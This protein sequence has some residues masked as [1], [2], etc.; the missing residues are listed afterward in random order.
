MG[1]KLA[2][3]LGLAKGEAHKWHI[4]VRFLV[5]KMICLS[6]EVEDCLILQKI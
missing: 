4:F 6:E 3:Y 2:L 1:S 5:L